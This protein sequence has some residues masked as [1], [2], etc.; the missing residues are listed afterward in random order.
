[1]ARPL[2]EEIGKRR[3]FDAVEQEAFLSLSRTAS[4]LGCEFERLFKR[5]G[6]SGA[7]YNVL[8][9]LRGEAEGGGG[10]VPMHTMGCRLI[11]RVPDV[12]RLVDRLEKAGLVGRGRTSQDRRVVLVSITARGLGLLSTLDGPVRDLHRA[13]LSHMTRAELKELIGLLGK[14]REKQG[15][16]APAGDC[17]ARR[18]EPLKESRR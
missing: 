15:A 1:V 7:A 13:Q 8:R 17:A 14:T 10:G 4:I 18:R 5:H 6:I 12:T 11:A 9:V 16:R 3:P 2:K